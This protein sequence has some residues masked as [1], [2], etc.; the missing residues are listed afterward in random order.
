MAFVDNLRKFIKPSYI[1]LG[2]DFRFG[3]Q[4]RGDV[5]Q[6]KQFFKIKTVKV[7]PTYKTTIIKNYILKGNVTMANKLL[8]KPYLISGIVKHGKHIGRKLGYPTANIKLSPQTIQ[9]KEGSYQAYTYINNVKYPSA[10]FIRNHL[11]ESH[12]FKFHKNIYGKIISVELI[13][14]HHRMNKTENFTSLQN[15]IKNKVESIQSTFE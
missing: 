8:F 12:V 3:K 13:K 14:Y 1:I 11:L 9:P 7:T 2:S 6:L 4:R 10:V 5:N 15:V